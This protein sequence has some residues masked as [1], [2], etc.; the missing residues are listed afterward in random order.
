MEQSYHEIIREKYVDLYGEKIIV[1][2]HKCG[3]NNQWYYQYVALKKEG[4]FYD[5]K[6]ILKLNKIYHRSS[7]CINHIFVVLD[8]LE[9]KK[10]INAITKENYTIIVIED[11]NTKIEVYYPDNI[12][13]I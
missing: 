13:F 1:I 8:D 12:V 3:M 4:I 10:C 11:Y 9:Y 6:K 2:Y 5:I 7:Y